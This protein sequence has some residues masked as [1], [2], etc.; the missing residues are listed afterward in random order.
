MIRAWIGMALLAVSWL[1]GLEYYGPANYP[2]WATVVVLGVVLLSGTI[3]R[4]PGRRDAWIALALLLPAMWFTPWPYRAAPLL[5]MLGLAAELAPIPRRWAKSLGRGALVAGVVMLVQGLLMVSYAAQTARSHELPWPMPQVLAGVASLLGIEAVA[6]GS[7]VAMHSM[8]QVH[9]F[10]ATWELLL[11]PQ[12]RGQREFAYATYHG[13]QFGLYTQRMI[14]DRRY[15]YVWNATDVDEFYDLE[16]DPWEMWNLA[17]A[18][19]HRELVRR[20]RKTLYET[21]DEMGDTMVQNEWMRHQ[22]L[23]M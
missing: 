9:Y 12:A 18:E 8:R 14:R 15:K 3:A 20:Y 13:Q 5:I 10:G 19:E 7:T 6:D 11:D 23:E 17:E 2:A 16:A 22:L 21:A 4:G 1:L